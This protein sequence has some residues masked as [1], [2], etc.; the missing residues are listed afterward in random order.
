MSLYVSKCS[1]P[2]GRWLLKPQGGDYT[3]GCLELSVVVSNSPSAHP[4]PLSLVTFSFNGSGP[5]LVELSPF[6]G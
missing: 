3:F 4:A 5:P 1:V 6:N 2:K